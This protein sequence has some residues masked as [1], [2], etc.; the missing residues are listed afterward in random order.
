MWLQKKD[1]VYCGKKNFL[2]LCRKNI[3][4]KTANNTII[5]LERNEDNIMLSNINMR[6]W[7]KSLFT[8]CNLSNAERAINYRRDLEYHEQAIMFNPETDYYNPIDK[9]L[10]LKDEEIKEMARIIILSIFY[11]S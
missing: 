6:N 1:G 8:V 2:N 5:S 11:I 4:D 7:E 3:F 10:N 9:E